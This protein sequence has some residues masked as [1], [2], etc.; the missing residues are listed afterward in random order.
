MSV[1]G[2]LLESCVS[3][4]GQYEQ[5]LRDTGKDYDCTC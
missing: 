1:T 5:E 2:E 4:Q 3:T